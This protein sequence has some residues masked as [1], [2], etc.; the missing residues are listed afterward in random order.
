MSDD[1]I[2]EKKLNVL[3]AK[4]TLQQPAEYNFRCWGPVI[5]PEGFVYEDIF[6]DAFWMHH[7][8]GRI[9]VNDLIRLIAYDNSFDLNVTVVDKFKGGLRVEAWP[10]LPAV[11]ALAA[12]DAKRGEPLE[13]R[14]VDGQELPRVEHT[15]ATKWRVIG[16]DGNELSR[17]HDSKASA[18]EAMIEF[19]KS[20][21]KT[22]VPAA[23]NDA[24]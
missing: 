23:E 15:R 19:Y 6:N 13:I 4:G 24:A 22:L 21:G 16:Y 18:T 11:S 8:S 17:G 7:A 5:L 14:I 9:A 2:A 20:K 10:K 12:V 1:K 3:P